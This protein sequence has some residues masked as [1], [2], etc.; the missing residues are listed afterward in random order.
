MPYYPELGGRN[1]H[2]YHVFNTVRPVSSLVS[3]GCIDP[4]FPQPL[5]YKLPEDALL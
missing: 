4:S 5:Y 3:D 1:G 2:Q